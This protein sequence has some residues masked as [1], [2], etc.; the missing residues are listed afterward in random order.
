[1][2]GRDR[3]V[4]FADIRFGLIDVVV[5]VTVVVTVVVI[6]FLVVL[7]GAAIARRVLFQWF[8]C[9]QIIGTCAVVLIVGYIYF[10]F[11]SRPKTRKYRWKQQSTIKE[12]TQSKERSNTCKT[13]FAIDCR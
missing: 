13:D 11:M 2:H 3:N 7:T 4:V 1:L 12:T 5:V 10:R 6:L 9:W 8:G